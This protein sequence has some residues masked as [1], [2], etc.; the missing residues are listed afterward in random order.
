MRNASLKTNLANIAK[1]RESELSVA[2]PNLYEMR[3]ICRLSNVYLSCIYRIS[4]VYLSY[5]YR[6][7]IVFRCFKAATEVLPF[8]K[9]CSSA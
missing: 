8:V 6:V 1:M 9:K 7:S 2:L 4:I 3:R 5:I